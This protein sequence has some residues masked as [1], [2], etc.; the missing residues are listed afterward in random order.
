MHFRPLTTGY[1]VL[2]IQFYAKFKLNG[3]SKVSGI[4]KLTLSVF[5]LPISLQ[6]R[7]PPVSLS[8]CQQD[9]SRP[10]LLM[11]V[12]E[13]FILPATRTDIWKFANQSICGVNEIHRKCHMSLKG[14]IWFIHLL[15]NIV[16]CGYSNAHAHP[17]SGEWAQL[18]VECI[19]KVLQRIDDIPN[20]TIIATHLSML[21]SQIPL[22]KITKSFTQFKRVHYF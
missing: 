21:F 14:N 6:L 5:C 12:M 17:V 9:N 4:T 10:K 11:T 15:E 8:V 18:G 22:R 16:D 20:W 13:I 1:P 7:F 3:N 2:V 19:F